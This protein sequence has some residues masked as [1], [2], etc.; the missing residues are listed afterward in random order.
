[1]WLFVFWV[2]LCSVIGLGSE[3]MQ[4]NRLAPGNK[5][6]LQGKGALEEETPA[7]LD[8]LWSKPGLVESGERERKREKNN[9]KEKVSL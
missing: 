3:G 4:T 9:Q 1:M 2:C 8:G 5:G 7:M 6:D